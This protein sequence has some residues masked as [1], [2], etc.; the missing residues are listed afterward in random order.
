MGRVYFASNL[1]LAALPSCRNSGC[2]FTGF[3]T[4][5]ASYPLILC[6]N[7]PEKLFKPL[8]KILSSMEIFWRAWQI[9]RQC[10]VFFINHL[11]SRVLFWPSVSNLCTYIATDYI[12]ESTHTH[13]PSRNC[14]PWPLLLSEWCCDDPAYLHSG[15]S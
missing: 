9:Y 11:S 1:S 14:T 10:K 15:A 5:F 3:A 7:E 6:W 8:Q 12:K 4:I 13:Y 2:H